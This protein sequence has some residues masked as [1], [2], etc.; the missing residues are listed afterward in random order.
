MG[1]VV[2]PP[3]SLARGGPVLESSVSM[4]GLMVTS[5]KGTPQPPGLLLPV[6]LTPGQAT[7]FGLGK[8]PLNQV[9]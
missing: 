5:S 3:C 6:P 2:P 1:G 9:E 7:G 4:V 8:H